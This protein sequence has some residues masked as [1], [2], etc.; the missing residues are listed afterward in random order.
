MDLMISFVGVELL[1]LMVQVCQGKQ[2]HKESVEHFNLII[3]KIRLAVFKV[4]NILKHFIFDSE[5]NINPV[6][7][8]NEKIF[9]I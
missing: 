6:N 3:I 2:V 9:E 7:N 8:F 1:F 5:N 4:E